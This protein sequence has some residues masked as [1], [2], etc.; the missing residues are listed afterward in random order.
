MEIPNAHFGPIVKD[1][2]RTWTSA[3][4]KSSNQIDFIAINKHKAN[5]VRNAYSQGPA[6]RN[7]RY[8]RKI[9]IAVIGAKYKKKERQKEYFTATMTYIG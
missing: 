8:G 1:G 3:G 6:R 2:I 4:G 9:I 5:R 7:S